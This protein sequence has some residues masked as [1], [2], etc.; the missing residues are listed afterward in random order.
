M[1]ARAYYLRSAQRKD[2]SG[3]L[4]PEKHKPVINAG[5]EKRAERRVLLRLAIVIIGV[6]TAVAIVRSLGV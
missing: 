6:I 4:P 5:D 2:G 3:L 1:Y